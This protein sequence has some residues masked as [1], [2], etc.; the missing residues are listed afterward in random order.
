M[1]LFQT[2][3]RKNEVEMALSRLSAQIILKSYEVATHNESFL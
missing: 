1:I 3:D 2:Y